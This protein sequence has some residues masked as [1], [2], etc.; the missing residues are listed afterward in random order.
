ML[1]PIDKFRET[2][3]I[4]PVSTAPRKSRP[5]HRRS[6][7]KLLWRDTRKLQHVQSARRPPWLYSVGH[8]RG[9]AEKRSTVDCETR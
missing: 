4:R 1:I 9:L 5:L 7:P 6:P 3:P 2:R 8:G